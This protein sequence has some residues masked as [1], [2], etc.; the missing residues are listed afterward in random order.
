MSR[1][2]QY[3]E[4]TARLH[5]ADGD[6]LSELPLSDMIRFGWLI[7]VPRPSEEMQAC[8]RFFGVPNVSTWRQVY[9]ELQETV[10]FRKS[11]SLDS[12]PGSVAAWLR[13]GEIE[14]ESVKCSPWHPRHFE[15]ALSRIRSLTRQKDPKLFIP[16]MR[17]ICAHC[18]VVVAVIR[19]PA[20][21]RASGA[22]RFVSESKALLM[23]SFRYLSDDQ[24]WFTFFHEAGHLLLHG[25]T[26]FFLEGLAAC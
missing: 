17:E 15:D 1:D 16:E 4:D 24:F 12:R 8:L 14:S 11:P 3:R 25:K 6:W 26:R 21:C 19:A 10:A 7:P 22:T 23:F 20:G 5:S 9:A 13:E 2:F 18:G